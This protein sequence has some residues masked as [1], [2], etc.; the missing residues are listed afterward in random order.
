MYERERDSLR[1]SLKLATQEEAIRLRSLVEQLQGQ[2]RGEVEE[3]RKRVVAFET[4]TNESLSERENRLRGVIEA[5]A[6]SAREDVERE[7]ARAER[8]NSRFRADFY[9]S[10]NQTFRAFGAW[11]ENLQGMEKLD[12]LQEPFISAPLDGIEACL[13][14]EFP[15]SYQMHTELKR[16]LQRVPEIFNARAGRILARLENMKHI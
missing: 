3:M 13:Q 7:L 11:I 5:S 12:W 16:I 10:A 9:S 2:L 14:K 8:G 1:E 15:V 4:N 6:K